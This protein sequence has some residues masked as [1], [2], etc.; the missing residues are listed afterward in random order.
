MRTPL[1]ADMQRKKVTQSIS[2]E[3][4]LHACPNED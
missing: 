3:M 1:V 4:Q 2:S